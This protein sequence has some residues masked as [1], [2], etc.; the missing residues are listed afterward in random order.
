MK[1]DTDRPSGSL[2]EASYMV[3]KSVAAFGAVVLA[4]ASGGFS[5]RI[6]AVCHVAVVGTFAALFVG[7]LANRAVR[8][9]WKAMRGG[10]DE[11]VDAAGRWWTVDVG[12][13]LAGDMAILG[14]TLHSGAQGR[15]AGPWWYILVV[16]AIAFFIWDGAMVVRLLRSK[17]RSWPM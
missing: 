4:A 12:P 14:Y 13:H 15:A 3:G 9:P 10:S 8:W 5:T 16:G 7:L 2:A 1:G 17:R 6:I 11:C